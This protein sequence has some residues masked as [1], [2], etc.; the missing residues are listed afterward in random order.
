MVM[1][2][3]RVVME[4]GEWRERERMHREDVE[5]LL[6]EVRERRRRDGSDPVYDFLFEYYSFK[7][8]KLAQWSPGVGVMLEGGG[9]ERVFGRRAGY[10]VRE[11]RA[12]VDVGE[13]EA[14]RWRGIDFIIKL[15]EGSQ[16]RPAFFGCYGM[17]EW[18]MV[19]KQGEEEV[20][21]R[22]VPLRMGR[23]G[24][25]EFVERQP[26]ICSHYDA[27][28]FFTPEA[29]PLNRLQPSFEGM[30]EQEQAG[31]LHTNMD[32][33]R[34]A[35]K[36]YPWIGSEVILEAF[37][38]AAMA[39]VLDMRAS[40]Y[41]LSGRGLEAIEIETVEGRQVYQ[42]EQRRV[43]ERGVV[44]REGLLSTYRGLREAVRGVGCV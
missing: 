24:V 34:W 27:F 38:L 28:R 41:D 33:Y 3:E 44:L 40:P 15:L 4:E 6:G 31:C 36:F 9:V 39:R 42:V 12:W 18:A 21:H 32:L 37:K 16:R 43:W 30:A 13:L 8:S 7:P 29:R 23:E 1:G 5:A 20:R 19:Y 22:R 11:G 35:Y 17:H 2:E 10:R 25:G 26:I 14:R